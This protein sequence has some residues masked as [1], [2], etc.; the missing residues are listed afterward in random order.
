MVNEMKDTMEGNEAK[1]DV[2]YVEPLTNS[3]LKDKRI[4]FLGSSVTLGACSNG[5]SFAD[6]IAR[7]N[8]ALCVKEA[9]NGTTLVD[10]GPDSYIARLERMDPSTP[11]DLFVCQLSTNDATKGKKLGEIDDASTQTIT[12]AV[13]YIYEYV[14]KT[15]GCPF[16]IYTS[17]HYPNAQYVG[18]VRRLQEL[19]R[20]IPGIHVIDMYSDEVFNRISESE[21]TLFLADPIHPTKAGYLL[22]L[23]PYIETALMEETKNK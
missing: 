14:K 22:W 9:V 19:S 15:W 13:R 21:R 5:V 10:D 20:Q 2:E 16:F 11:F 6:Y 4:A 23:T 1:Y 7:R 17:P 8:G 3:T 12:G 18:M